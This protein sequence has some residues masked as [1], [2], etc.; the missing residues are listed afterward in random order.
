MN[1]S[2]YYIAIVNVIGV[3]IKLVRIHPHFLLFDFP[4]IFSFSAFSLT[5]VHTLISRCLLT[6]LNSESTHVE[7]THRDFFFLLSR[8]LST[9]C[10]LSNSPPRDPNTFICTSHTYSSEPLWRIKLKTFQFLGNKRREGSFGFGIPIIKEMI[11]AHHMGH[12][13]ST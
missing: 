7:C 13:L 10:Q 5:K 1:W 6:V 2:F 3:K 9:R 11:Q 12:P 8:K 4:H